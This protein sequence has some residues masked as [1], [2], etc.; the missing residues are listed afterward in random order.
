MPF[1][2]SRSGPRPDKTA[3]SLGL[4]APFRSFDY[5]ANDA[6][7]LLDAEDPV[8][9]RRRCISSSSSYLE[10]ARAVDHRQAQRVDHER[11]SKSKV[12]RNIRDDGDSASQSDS[13][14]SIPEKPPKNY[15][16]KLRHKT[17]EDRYKLKQD[18]SGKEKMAR[19][20]NPS[21]KKKRKQNVKSGTALMLDF[22]AQNVAQ[23]RITVRLYPWT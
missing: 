2:S 17:R 13:V 6:D 15:E 9:K 19:K 20:S 8:R 12:N 22:S 10:T 1:L 16:R 23:D 21:K 11:L 14:V 5:K 18:G 7:P 3:T 4:D